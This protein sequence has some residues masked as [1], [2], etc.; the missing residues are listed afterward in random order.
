MSQPVCIIVAYAGQSNYI[1]WNFVCTPPQPQNNQLTVHARIMLHIMCTD[2]TPKR[3]NL[4]FPLGI[5][6][7]AI[8]ACVQGEIIVVSTGEYN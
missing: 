2:I 7:C 3:Q 4:K 6:M 1:T 5:F 8:N